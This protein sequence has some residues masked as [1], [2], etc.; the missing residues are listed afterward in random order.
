MSS[1][2]KP[3]SAAKDV[4]IYSSL[5]ND[6]KFNF[7]AKP[8]LGA[9]ARI[10][11]AI[12]IKGGAGVAH[13]KTLVTPYGVVTRLSADDYERLKKHDQYKAFE[14]AGHMFS[15]DVRLDEEVA[16]ADLDRDNSAPMTD[17]DFEANEDGAK[18]S[19]TGAA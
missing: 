8:V 17:E 11:A 5:A 6:Q 3:V 12:T 13:K 1:K 7:F 14:T 4:F 19:G 10:E 15:S 16:A 18:L 2:N 9:P